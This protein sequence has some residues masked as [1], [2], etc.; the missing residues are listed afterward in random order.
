MLIIF[1]SFLIIALVLTFD[2]YSDT[3]LFKDLLISSLLAFG[4]LLFISFL[5][6]YLLK[7][8]KLTINLIIVLLFFINASFIA[9]KRYIFNFYNFASIF[10]SIFITASIILTLLYIA[11][12]L[13]LTANSLIPIA[14]MITAAG[15]RAIVLSLSYYKSKLKDLEEVILNFFA[16]GA[17][18]KEVFKWLFKDILNNTTVVIRD[19]LKAA[20]IVHI[21]GVMVGLLIAGIF[22]IKA[23]IIQFALLSSMLFM[24]VFAPTI[25][26]NL[27][28]KKEF[29]YI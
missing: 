3:K 19:M 20:G 6:I 9:S 11:G 24:F 2:I 27:I 22:P 17:S 5:L 4:N 18:K 8:N 15:M 12:I 14:G 25:S 26:M 23:A 28:I 29:K 1:V 13:K 10:F 7:F 21:P 16:I